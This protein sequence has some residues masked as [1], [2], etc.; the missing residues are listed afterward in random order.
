MF[1]T[2]HPDPNGILRLGG[3]EPAYKGRKH[4][5]RTPWQQNEAQISA[6]NVR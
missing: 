3:N 1:D 5:R 4:G 6:H 2:P